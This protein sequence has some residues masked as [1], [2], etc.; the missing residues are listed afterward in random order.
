ARF[1]QTRKRHGEGV[2]PTANT[3]KTEIQK[4]L[5]PG[6][7]QDDDIEAGIQYRPNCAKRM[8]LRYPVGAGG[9]FLYNSLLRR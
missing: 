2:P 1:K 3:P 6:L 4:P 9:E 7:R 5:D 8:R